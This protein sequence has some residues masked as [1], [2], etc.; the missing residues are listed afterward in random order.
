MFQFFDVLNIDWLGK[1]RLFIY[2][3]VAI[4]LIGLASAIARQLSPGGTDAFNLGVDFK[5]GT[6]ATV[7]FSKETPSEDE[8][9][10]ALAKAGANEAQIQRVTNRPNQMMIKVPQH[11]SG[12]E[13]QDQA[14]VND[15]QKKITDALK[16]MEERTGP[17]I[18]GVDAVGPIAGAQLRNQA[19]SVTLLALVGVLLYIA[20]RFDALAYGAAAVL[21]VFHD[22]L[23]TLAFFS[24]FQ[25][26]IN[27]TVIAALLTLVGFSVNDTIVTFDRIRENIQLYRRESLYKITN[28][29]V[30]Q[31]L[32]RTIITA[33]LVFLSVLAL[34]L[35]GGDVLRGFSL[36]L[37]IG[38]V[39][40]TY[41]TIGI[42]SPIMLWW[43]KRAG[44]MGASVPPAGRSTDIRKPSERPVR[45]KRAVRA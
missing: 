19:I 12:N 35:F 40:G 15:G 31:T 8:V 13:A 37:L 32:S 18:I 4:M 39:V 28:D 21:A 38:V 41:S 23:V 29:A 24:I 26:E 2:I 25:W 22:V 20:F 9:R 33:S 42:A 45:E 5:P 7:E 27:L 1:R 16:G 17:K 30:N 10:Q 14:N 44:N 11:S 3:S 43:Q 6:F 36:A 34:V